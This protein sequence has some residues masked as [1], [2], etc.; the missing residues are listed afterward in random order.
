M[1]LR[2]RSLGDGHLTEDTATN[3]NTQS[4][5]SQGKAP[6]LAIK[7]DEEIEE[8]EEDNSIRYPGDAEAM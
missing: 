3:Q 6:G 1:K 5:I 8:E 2:Q 7:I 4:S